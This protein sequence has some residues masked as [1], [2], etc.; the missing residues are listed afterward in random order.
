ME[1][2]SQRS[3]A[4][5]CPHLISEWHPEKNST[6]SPY[7]VGART[8]KKV[9]WKCS[10]DHEWQTTPANRFAGTGCPDCSKKRASHTHNLAIQY[11]ALAKEW[12]IEKN[13]P[14][15]PNDVTPKSAKKVFWQCPINTTHV[16]E[17][18]IQNRVDSGNRRIG[19]GCPDCAG[20]RVSQ[21]HNLK[22]K[23]PDLAAEWHHSNKLSPDKVSPG[24]NQEIIWQCPKNN[25]HIW[26]AKVQSRALVKTNCPF[27]AGRKAS[28]S[29]NLEK[30]HPELAKEWHPEKNI[31]TP[32]KFTPGSRHKAWWICQKKHEWPAQIYPRVKGSGCPK[33]SPPTSKQEIRL[34]CELRSIFPD[35]KSLDKSYGCEIDIL[36]PNYQLAI[37]FDGWY[38]HKDTLE[39]D[40]RK[41][42]KLQKKGLN[43]LRVRDKDLDHGNIEFVVGFNKMDNDIEIV[44]NTL[45]FIQN[46]FNLSSEELRLINEYLASS[47]YKND[48][49]YQEIVSRL[50]GPLGKSLADYP[51]LVKEW[52][53][54][55][56]VIKPD[57]VAYGSNAKT[58]WLCEKNHEWDATVYSRV[59]GR[60]CPQCSKKVP[61]PTNNFAVC[62]PHLVKEW[63]PTKNHSFK[64]DNFT[65]Q[66]QK[67]VWWQCEN[68][69]E[70]QAVIGN[71]FS[72]TTC[73]YCAGRK[74]FSD[75][76]LAI[77]NPELLKE[78][79]YEKNSPLTPYNVTH[80]STRKVWWQCK[81][82]HT[83]QT[84]IAH[85]TRG[86]GCHFCS[87][88][89]ASSENNLAVK[90][91]DLAT[92]WDYSKNDLDPTQVLCGSSKKAYWICVKGHSWLAQITS[93]T[94]L[95]G[96][97]CPFCSGKK[98]TVNN[99]LAAK[100]PD[101]AAEWDYSKNNSHASQILCGSSKKA[102]WICRKGHSWLAQIK[103][104][105]KINGTGCPHCS[106]ENR[107]IHSKKHR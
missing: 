105:T 53:P 89:K 50:P 12:H 3:I 33:C 98:A 79:D 69:H 14:L 39:K 51:D 85:R 11:P 104:R 31:N 13:K 2:K 4:A 76:N 64:P 1:K 74:A 65:P 88:Y 73:P 49:E 5:R 86:H 19:T 84:T 87:K 100:R 103:R 37:E 42:L 55:K 71:R 35:T 97:S 90:R 102:Y 20:R 22:S 43:V 45:K 72:G 25:E 54:S 30:M 101:L 61:S 59:S 60:K 106:I 93:R 80:K 27:C 46:N 94:K 15:T 32:D 47:A 18:K 78:W 28:K 57:Q 10:K 21:E 70:W 24:S 107:K 96:T 26:R 23:Y 56:N 99:N 77:S 48:C 16:W 40:K 41:C 9:W 75:Y 81:L 17:A 66:S 29:Y 38:W 52:H 63:H 62:C 7:Y 44:K 92:E 68:K 95:N 67:K 58:W 36:I 6:L 8:G 82:F 83:W 91:P 34:F